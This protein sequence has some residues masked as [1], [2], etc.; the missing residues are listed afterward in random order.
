MHEPLELFKLDPID[1]KVFFCLVAQPSLSAMTYWIQ[2]IAADY[3]RRGVASIN[4]SKLFREAYESACF[5]SNTSTR[6]PQA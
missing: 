2:F 4:T 5:S 6:K 1:R 3:K